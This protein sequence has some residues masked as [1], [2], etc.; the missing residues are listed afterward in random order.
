MTTGLRSNSWSFMG[1]GP[2]LLANCFESPYFAFG[3]ILEASQLRLNAPASAAH[4]FPPF[5]LAGYES[6]APVAGISEVGTVLLV[7]RHNP[8]LLSKSLLSLASPGEEKYFRKIALAQLVDDIFGFGIDAPPLP[9]SQK[10]HY[11]FGQNF[12]VDLTALLL[13]AYG[14]T[15]QAE[16]LVSGVPTEIS[17]Q[18]SAGDF[19]FMFKTDPRFYEQYPDALRGPLED[20]LRRG[21]LGWYSS[22]DYE[23]VSKIR[24]ILT[25]YYAF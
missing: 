22:R 15:E 25:G 10:V 12:A 5:K 3:S 7:L 18:L 14:R 17:S 16:A 6:V 20:G 4:T 13:F 9:T 11:K 24:E 1:I 21:G 23:S 8:D 2:L 19:D